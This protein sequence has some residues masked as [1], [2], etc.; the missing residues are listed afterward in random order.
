MRLSTILLGLSMSVMTAQ[1]CRSCS[2]TQL[3]EKSTA[4]AGKVS[5][6]YIVF[7]RRLDCFEM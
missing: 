6:I 7:Q 1:T 4:G 2:R 5:L 3:T